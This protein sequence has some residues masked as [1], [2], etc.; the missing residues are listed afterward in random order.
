MGDII[1]TIFSSFSDVI[2]NM[3]TGIKDAFMNILYVDPMA[4]EKVISDPVKFGL[5]LVGM[6]MAVGLVMG[7][8]HFIRARKG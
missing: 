5:I 1:T 8:L 2:T 7:A 4:T 3:A 6:S